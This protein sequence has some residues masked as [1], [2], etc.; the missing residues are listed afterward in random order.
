MQQQYVLV[1]NPN[2]GKTSLFN[3]MTGERQRVGNFPGITV[4]LR[5]GSI[6]VAEAQGSLL[7]LPGVYSLV[8]QQQISDDER[9]TID[10]LLQRQSETIINVVDA[11]SLERQI[12]L[13][14]QLREMGLPMVVVLSKLDLALSQGLHIDTDKLAQQLGCPVIGLDGR[15]G[16]GLEQLYHTLA[17]T[18]ALAQQQPLAV[19]Y[20]D[21]LEQYLAAEPGHQRVVRLS[22]AVESQYRGEQVVAVDVELD[23]ASARY[24][25]CNEL[26]GQVQARPSDLRR[27]ITDRLDD[28]LMQPWV[29]LPAFIFAMYLMFSFAINVGGAFIDFFDIAAGALFIDGVGALLSMLGMPDWVTVILADGVGSGIQT[30]A[31][32]IPQIACL[33]LFLTALEQSGYLARAATIVDRMMLKMGLPGS[34][35]VPMLMG[36]GCSVPAV[37]ATRTLKQRRERIL[38][39]AMAHFMSC[40][41]RLPVY[42]LF[43][44]AFFPEYGQELV[45]LLYVIG[46][47][48]AILT[49]FVLRHTVL[50][51]TSSAFIIEL[52]DYQMPNM[53]EMV[54]NTWFRLRSFIFGAGKT[55][56]V[57]VAILSVLNSLGRDGSFGHE[58]S[59][60]SVLAVT[61]KAVTPV[62]TPLGIEQDNWQATVGIITGVFAKEAVVGTLNSLYSGDEDSEPLTLT[63]SFAEAFATIGTN[64]SALSDAL[65]DPLG[66]RVEDATDLEVTAEE[67]GVAVS[68]IDR[69][70]QSFS[71]ASAAFAYLLFV[72]LYIPCASA[73]GAMVREF[74]GRWAVLIGVWS[75]ALAYMSATLFYQIVQLTQGQGAA[76]L[77]IIAC[78]AL[79]TGLIIVLKTS[80]A[81]RWLR[82]NV[83]AN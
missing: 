75:T 2:V 13:T 65:L 55:I 1:G 8:P 15:T 72:L 59:G 14:V 82:L 45:L 3:L 53:R 70:G 21:E 24:R 29:A 39:G 74:G 43:A 37:M 17:D 28:W 23:I 19:R 18:Q 60:E 32:F 50:P 71:S 20:C 35:F 76:L 44:A 73:M 42:A 66:I 31:T 63:Q 57:V 64:L 58:N 33:F 51:G 27:N 48:M 6:A 9:V 56:V 77:V 36:F 26:V 10:Y 69:L 12:Y 67:Q 30:V 38:T 80:P 79:L 22:Q 47:L 54:I 62:F 25:F 41:A 4:A 61:A 7:D 81:K 68:T 78:I 46:M 52:P 34:A 16:K 40:G 83:V 49:G 11:T 5:R